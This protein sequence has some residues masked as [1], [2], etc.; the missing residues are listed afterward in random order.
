MHIPARAALL[1]LLPIANVDTAAIAQAPSAWTS[2]SPPG[3]VLPSAGAPY[4]AEAIPFRV[5]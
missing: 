4:V 5:L 1:L 3:G 2:L